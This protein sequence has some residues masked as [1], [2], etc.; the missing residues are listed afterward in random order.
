M[1]WGG[2]TLINVLAPRIV[3]AV[4]TLFIISL[5]IF[6]SVE[7]LP[8]DTAEAMLGHDATVEA[9]ATLRRELQLDSP[10]YVRYWRWIIDLLHGDL[11]KSLSSGRA[12]SDLLAQRLPNTFFLAGFA[13]LISVPLSFVLG[14]ITALY[15]ERAVDRGVNFV[16]LAA[17]SLPDFF[18]AY[19]LILIFSVHLGWVPP[20]SIISPESSLAERLYLTGLPALTLT[21]ATSAYML[22]MTRASILSLLS[23]PYIEMARLKGVSSGRVIVGHALPNAL[24]PI[25]NVTALTLAYLVVSVVVVETVFAYPGLGQLF[26]DSVSKRDIPVVQVVAMVFASTYIVLNL[27]ADMV[28]LAANPRLMHPR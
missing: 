27:V 15:R 16:A 14:V 11:G 6:F 28:A 9:L 13:A 21:F 8:G 25:A 3:L 18:V 2:R 22:R 20:I 23:S 5:V 24:G 10:A 17:S 4:L 12:V 26:V 7:L 19:A 1:N